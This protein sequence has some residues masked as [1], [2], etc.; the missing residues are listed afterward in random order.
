LNLFATT[1]APC[2]RCQW[3]EK[4]MLWM[5]QSGNLMATGN[6]VKEYRG[7]SCSATATDER[8]PRDPN[9]GT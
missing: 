8:A 1:A 6:Y 9:R 7:R 4:A 3:E 2:E 5:P